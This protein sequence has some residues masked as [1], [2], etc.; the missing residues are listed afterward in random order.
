ML[1]DLLGV[2]LIVVG[3]VSAFSRGYSIAGPSQPRHRA[4]VSD[5]PW[6]SSTDERR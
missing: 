6:P 2:V 1:I 5:H 3:L 4:I